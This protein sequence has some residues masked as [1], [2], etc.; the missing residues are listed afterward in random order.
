MRTYYLASE[1]GDYM[2]KWM[3]VIRAA[4]LMQNFSEIQTRKMLATSV[5][6][7]TNSYEPNMGMNRY[8][9]DQYRNEQNQ[10]KADVHPS[11]NPFL[12]FDEGN[13]IKWLTKRNELNCLL[14]LLKLNE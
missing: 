9:P 3:R 7:S 11:L 10:R 12:I 4:T 5:P 1:N 2:R 8:D 6:I 14:E 13:Y